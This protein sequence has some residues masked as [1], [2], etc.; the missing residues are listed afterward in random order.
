MRKY[1]YYIGICMIAS[2]L[3]LGGWYF[4][5]ISIPKILVH[6]STPA[7]IQHHLQEEIEQRRINSAI[8]ASAKLYET[9]G[10]SPSLA[11]PTAIAAIEYNLPVRL[12]TAIVIVESS[13]RQTAI[14]STGAVGLMQVIPSWHHTSRRAL[15]NRDTNLQIGTKFLASLIR[16][17]GIEQGVANYHGF[18]PD[19]NA[20]WDYETQVMQVAGY[21]GRN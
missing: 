1:M 16:K 13:C 7:E 5:Y 6:I 8:N 21:Q 11:K 12:A 14:S 3:S 17:Y 4:Q 18:V 19:E 10:C 20:G 2:V 9:H 15:L